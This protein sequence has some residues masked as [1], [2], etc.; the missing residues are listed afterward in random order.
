M[1]TLFGGFPHAGDPY[2]QERAAY[3]RWWEENGRPAVTFNEWFAGV[4]QG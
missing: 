2:K 1:T 4:R 3:F